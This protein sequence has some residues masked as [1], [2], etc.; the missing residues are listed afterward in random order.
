MCG[1]PRIEAHQPDIEG[2]SI[3]QNIVTDAVIVDA[4]AGRGAYPVS[5][6]RNPVETEEEDELDRLE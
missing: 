4:V 6:R 5:R 1:V 2:F 3:A